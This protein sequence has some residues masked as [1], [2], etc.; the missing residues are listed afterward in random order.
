MPD[1]SS[2]RFD[3]S[4]LERNFAVMQPVDDSV[5]ASDSTTPACCSRT[6]L[7]IRCRHTERGYAL[8]LPLKTRKPNESPNVP[9]QNRQQLVMRTELPGPFLQVLS[10]HEGRDVAEVTITGQGPNQC[11][12]GKP[13]RVRLEGL[14][15]GNKDVPFDS[16]AF[17]APALLD[18]KLLDQPGDDLIALLHPFKMP[19]LAP[20]LWTISVPGCAAAKLKTTI[21]AFP[22][23]RWSGQLTLRAESNDKERSGY[24]ITAD[25][26]LACT[27]NGHRLELNTQQQ[28]IVLCPWFDCLE[29]LAR[30]AVAVLALRPSAR[31]QGFDAP[32]LV[33]HGEFTWDPWPQLTLRLD[34]ALT[35]E[36]GTGLIGHQLRAQVSGE[37][38]IG[39][40]GEISLL[41]KWLQEPAK[42]RLLTPV[43]AAI[44]ARRTEEICEELGLWLVA[45][46][47]A[48]L[49]AGVEARR[50]GF[51]TESAGKVTGSVA[52]YLQARST[53]EYE[54]L[55]I[56][57]GSSTDSTKLSGISVGLTPP[58]A[59]PLPEPLDRKFQAAVNFTGCAVSSMEKC[60]PGI[61]FRSLRPADNPKPSPVQILPARIWPSG[62]EPDQLAEIEWLPK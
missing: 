58:P 55:I 62:T 9:P 12:P 54:T 51:A 18:G 49:R 41:A 6:A 46:G 14:G 32:A 26:T 56:R 33:R 25:S 59:T 61:R 16:W 17:K 45:D 48:S 19:D 42:T 40:R 35:E 53:R 34:A 13:N 39:A 31:L 37:P 43:L 57:H 15:G 28:A 27:Y 10:I 1:P 3:S 36:K 2:F 24:Q 20:Q 8:E 52:L 29:P 44:E 23:V 11:P 60:R 5:Q 50:P 38:L 22:D 4:Q 21:A 47:R 7:I 30:S